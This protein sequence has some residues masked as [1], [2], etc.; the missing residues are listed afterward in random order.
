[1]HDY[2]IQFSYSTAL[3]G[4]TGVLAVFV[5]AAEFIWEWPPLGFLSVH[6]AAASC[7]FRVR[8]WF[9]AT[10]HRERNAFELGQDSARVHQLR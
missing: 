10:A 5:L 4:L 9:C 3:A 1:M 6:L 8:S 2:R 7:L